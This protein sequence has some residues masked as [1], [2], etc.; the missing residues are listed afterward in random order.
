MDESVLT[1]N[2]TSSVILPRGVDYVRAA[3]TDLR[4]GV[5]YFATDTAP[6][7]IAKVRH[8]DLAL[9]DVIVLR[10]DA[11]GGGGRFIRAGAMHP[12]GGV[13]YWATYTSP[14]RGGGPR[15]PII[16]AVHKGS[17]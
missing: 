5:S 8:S 2:R 9:L 6:A 13:S 12:L 4:A 1:L 11:I 17:F 7:V 14:I 16:T 10:D 15:R 3:A